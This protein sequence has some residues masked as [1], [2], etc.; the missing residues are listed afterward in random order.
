MRYQ[1]ALLYNA[2]K[3]ENQGKTVESV[4]TVVT[5][6]VSPDFRRLYLIQ[7]S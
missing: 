6:E 2:Q 3:P 1:R 5:V 4:V 7:K